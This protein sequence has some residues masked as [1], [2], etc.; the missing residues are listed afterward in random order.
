MSIADSK[1]AR[2]A[3]M[4]GALGVVFGD[5]GTSPLYALREC[6]HHAHGIQP[7]V[8]N[9]LGEL[10]LIFWSLILLVSIK[11][12]GL[13]LRADNK[14]EGGIL[15]LLALVRPEQERRKPRLGLLF[16]MG[17]FGAGLLYGDGML[18][19]SL[20]VLSAIEGLTVATRLFEPYIVPCSAVILVLLFMIQKHGTGKVGAGFGPVMLLWFS[21]LAVLGIRGIL[22]NP[23]V[24]W[25]FNPWYGLQFLFHHGRTG[26]LV[27][28]SVFLVVTGVE[29]LYA[30][31]G[32]FGAS[33]IRRAW[34]AMVMPALFLNYM[35]Q[36]ALIL[37]DPSAVENPFYLLAPGWALYPMVA[38][39][40]LAAIIASQALISGVFSL[41]MQA[42]QLG[43]LPRIAV[44]HTSAD[45]RGQIYIPQTNWSL[46]AA[47]L[48]L[49]AS[50]Q[51]SSRLAAAYGIA[52][53]LTMVI[54]SVLFY[55]VA[56]RL[57]K[58]RRRLAVPLVG[59]FLL[60]EVTFCSANMAKVWHGGWVPLVIGLAA[61]A[62]MSTWRAG[63]ILLGERLARSRMPLDQFFADLDA[64][65]PVRVPGTAVFMSGTTQGVPI[66]LLHNYKHNRVLH[67]QNV[68]LTVI[69]E[70]V[71]HVPPGE[72]IHVE[73]MRE[74][75]H[76]VTVRVG[77]MDPVNVAEVLKACASQGLELHLAKTSFF[78]SRETI[79]H[80]RE[81][82]LARWRKYLFA[83]LSR[84]A[85]RPT[86]YFGLPPNRVVE[87]GMQV[88]I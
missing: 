25:S 10:S 17:I 51:S 19:P 1:R 16:A 48:L 63:R 7:D 45:L 31:M 71:S 22:L 86:D 6:F 53:S 12:A 43:L 59:F 67:L 34:F 77:F 36:G 41:T 82:S 73:K 28:G 4:L 85:Q 49:V 35:G 32:H 13:I 9:V 18:T 33:P 55:L 52:V 75:F 23:H 56:R 65:R 37:R 20:T 8:A 81:R 64:T 74:G 78:V 38:L 5:I 68:F 66:A 14:G 87:L 57:W 29:A 62:V 83:I 42:T 47:C 76:R 27:L 84:N 50:F 80:G 30:D 54:T 24:L 40:T 11:Y 26:F 58:W 46:L 61:F 3:L 88:E 2:F 60:V 70:N 15:A 79:L 39:A 69:I 72:R 44:R 21:V